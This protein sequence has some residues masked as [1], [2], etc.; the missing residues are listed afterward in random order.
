MRAIVAAGGTIDKEWPLPRIFAIGDQ[1]T[2]TH[3]L[4][5]M[6]TQWSDA[7]VFVDL[8]E[9]WGELGIEEEKTTIKFDSR[10]SLAAIRMAITNPP[11]S[12]AIR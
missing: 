2:G 9:L 11:K 5:E 6:Y 1:A 3:V 12:S 10:A 4:E 8:S 7:P